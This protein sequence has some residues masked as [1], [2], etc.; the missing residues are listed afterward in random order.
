MEMEVNSDEDHSSTRFGVTDKGNKRT[1]ILVCT[2]VASLGL[3]LFRANVV[4]N[5]VSLRAVEGTL[6]ID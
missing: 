5:L 6:N 1:R 2:Q 4:I 3:N